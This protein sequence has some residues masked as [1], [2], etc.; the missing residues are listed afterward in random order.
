M[1]FTIIEIPENEIGSNILDAYKY[2]VVDT[3]NQ[4]RWFGSNVYQECVDYIGNY[5]LTNN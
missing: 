5:T 3:E 1:I 4:T 2:M